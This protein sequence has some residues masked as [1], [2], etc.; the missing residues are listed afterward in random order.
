M[1]EKRLKN[2][3]KSSKI[4]PHQP[5]KYRFPV[6]VAQRCAAR[7]PQHYNRLIKII[8]FVYGTRNSQQI[9]GRIRIRL[10]LLF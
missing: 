2:L 5:K 8:T 6:E 10:V 7:E 1:L 4:N 9:K 3:D